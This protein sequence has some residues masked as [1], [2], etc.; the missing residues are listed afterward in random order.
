MK[1]WKPA[2]VRGEPSYIC[3]YCSSEE[4]YA[5]VYNFCGSCGQEL[6]RARPFREDFEYTP[7]NGWK[8]KE[9]VSK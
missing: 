9:K 2:I 4:P 3:P 1:Q 6:E 5:V 8:L 7:E